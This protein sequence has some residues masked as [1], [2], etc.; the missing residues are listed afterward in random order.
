MKFN[1]FLLPSKNER[2]KSKKLFFIILFL[3]FPLALYAGWETR[4]Y[5]TSPADDDILTIQVLILVVL[6][7]V[8]VWILLLRG[9]KIR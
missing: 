5:L 9:L 1:K 6:L 3:F 8:F 2:S 7:K 4:T